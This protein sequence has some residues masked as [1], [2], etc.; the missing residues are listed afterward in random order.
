MTFVYCIF[1]INRKYY[2]QIN[3]DLKIRG[4]QHI[5]AI[6]PEIKILKK[7]VKNKT[8]YEEVPVL[9][10]YGFIKM[11]IDKAYS[12][13]FLNKLKR[14]IPGIH[15]WLKSSESMFPKK[16][17]RRID[18]AEDFDDFSKV[19]TCTRKEVNRFKKIAKLNKLFSLEDILNIREGQYVQ[20]KIYPY[21]GTEAR[22]I[23]INPETK[24]ATLELYPNMG[25]FTVR[26]PLDHVIYSVYKDYDPDTFVNPLI[27]DDNRVTQ[28]LAE[29]S[30]QNKRQ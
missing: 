23:S 8:F 10:N 17:K 5:K 14:A 3:R 30:F 18:N 4:F 21:E 22:V 7:S 24:M 29:E 1:Y 25:S 6:V 13:Q 26:I 2:K 12:R 9:F 20:L 11:P 15:N 19:A 16:K 27:Y 28:E